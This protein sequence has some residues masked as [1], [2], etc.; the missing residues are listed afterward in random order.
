MMTLKSKNLLIFLLIFLNGTLLACSKDASSPKDNNDNQTDNI[1]KTKIESGYIQVSKDNNLFY[2]L[3]RSKKEN[4][5]LLIH[6]AGGP[7]ASSLSPAFFS[8]GPYL[9]NDP[10]Q[11]DLNYNLKKN[12]YSW[13]NLANTVFLEQ[14]RY[15]G[16]SFGSGSYITSLKT[17]GEEFIIWLKEFYK[18]YPEFEKL[19]LYLSGESA[20]GEFIAEFS[21]QILIYN[22][23]NPK[24]QIP[25]TGLF[26]QAAVIGNFEETPAQ[27]KLILLCKQEILPKEACSKNLSG[28]L[29]SNLDQCILNI[30]QNKKIPIQNV[31][32]KDISNFN[33][34]SP[35]PYCTR[36]INETFIN[37]LYQT[38][39]IYPNEPIYPEEFR[40]QKFYIP[41]G[42]LE[43]SSNSQIRQNLKYSPNTYNLK[44]QCKQSDFFPPWCYDGYKLS[45]FFNDPKIKKWL[46]KGKVPEKLE[47][48]FASFPLMLIIEAFD[49]ENYNT[50]SYFAEALKNNI[51]V[52]IATGKNDFMV[53]YISSQAITNKIAQNAYGNKIFKEFPAN[54]SEL[55][56]LVI[57]GQEKQFG[58]YKSLN[59]LKFIQVDNSGH[60][61]GF[62]QP[63]VVYQ[64][65]KNLLDY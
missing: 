61:I 13:S 28:N 34:T 31:Q 12:S 36:Y 43:F 11:H 33:K 64:I 1:L 22:E 21:H 56:K 52:V 37:T 57:D 35:N 27:S 62:D 7:G 51:K 42:S 49:K 58:E 17:A 47:W 53:D 50:T 41:M 40:G 44:I 4:A 25:L 16:Y 46:G 24:K 32:T 39:F 63:E 10:F 9:I 3:A 6:F 38:P 29:Q 23:D 60:I 18:K 2:F 65:V 19:P 15:V 5:P 8:Y 20:G 45:N 55:K 54:S 14:T 48:K 30:A 59:K 26:A